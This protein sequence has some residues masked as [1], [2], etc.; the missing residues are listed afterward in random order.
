MTEPKVT[1]ITAEEAESFRQRVKAQ[2][3]V[4]AQMV[5]IDVDEFVQ[6][7]ESRGWTSC[8]EYGHD[9][10]NR[11]CTDCGEEYEE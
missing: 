3:D 6:F 9:F 4:I 2:N 7:V 10:V 5:V 11:R 8:E 1:R